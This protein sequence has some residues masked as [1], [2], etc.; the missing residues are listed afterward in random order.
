MYMYVMCCVVPLLAGSDDI[1]IL[2]C[3]QPS[4]PFTDSSDRYNII[5]Y[6]Y[7]LYMYIH[8]YYVYTC[9]NER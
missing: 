5:I 9:F 8:A 6:L 1:I 7:A 4:K 2:T 3:T